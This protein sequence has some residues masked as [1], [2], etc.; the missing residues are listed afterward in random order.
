MELHAGMW[1]WIATISHATGHPIEKPVRAILSKN[2]PLHRTGTGSL[3]TDGWDVTYPYAKEQWGCRA[4]WQPVNDIHIENP[5]P[6][7]RTNRHCRV[8][9]GTHA[10]LYANGDQWVHAECNDKS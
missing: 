6:L 2:R 3:I 4:G 8:C 9:K 7:A 5:D 1:V 10:H